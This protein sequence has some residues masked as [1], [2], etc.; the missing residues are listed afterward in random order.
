MRDGS[1]ARLSQSTPTCT[2]VRP[3]RVPIKTSRRRRAD[4]GPGGSGWNLQITTPHRRAS[5]RLVTC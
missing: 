2:S 3:D 1:K 4:R 5:L